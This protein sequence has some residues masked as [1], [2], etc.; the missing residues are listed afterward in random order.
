MDKTI[1][2]RYTKNH[3]ECGLSPKLTYKFGLPNGKYTVKMYFA[4]PW[5]GVSTNPSVNANGTQLANCATGAE[6]SLTATVSDGTLTLN[7]TTSNLCINI[8][9]IVIALA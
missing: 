5:P 3:Y 9:Y 7:F 1:S 6:V 8:A 2:N 4:D